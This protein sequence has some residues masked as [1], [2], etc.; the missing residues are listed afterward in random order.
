M[1][2]EQ[3]KRFSA[4]T[5]K[6]GRHKL[7]RYKAEFTKMPD[8]AKELFLDA[9]GSLFY[10]EY[11]CTPQ[12]FIALTELGYTKVKQLNDARIKPSRIIEYGLKQEYVPHLKIFLYPEYSPDEDMLIAFQ[13][14][15]VQNVIETAN[16]NSYK[17]YYRF[18]NVKVPI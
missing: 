16:K 13:S 10:T 12:E 17:S 18:S 9:H 4:I 15:S 7:T 1:T 2:P 6:R 8:V 11:P 14:G 3:K 5:K